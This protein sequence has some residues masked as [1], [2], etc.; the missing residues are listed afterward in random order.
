MNDIEYATHFG[1]K[2]VVKIDTKTVHFQSFVALGNE[3]S[4]LGTSF[5]RHMNRR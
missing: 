1:D 4:R 2:I 3:V 5:R